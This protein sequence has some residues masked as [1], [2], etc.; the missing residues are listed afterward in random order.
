MSD[1]SSAASSDPP[2][3]LQQEK[4]QGIRRH[5]INRPTPTQVKVSFLSLLHHQISFRLSLTWLF[6]GEI[7]KAS[8]RQNARIFPIP[9]LTIIYSLCFVCCFL[10]LVFLCW[11]RGKELLLFQIFFL[12]N[13]HCEWPTNRPS[14]G[15]LCKLNKVGFPAAKKTEQ[16]KTCQRV[17]VNL[18]DQINNSC[19]ETTVQKHTSNQI[20]MIPE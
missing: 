20:R 13:L 8:L 15:G 5:P 14:F 18:Y 12:K 2:I 11:I 16:Q 1:V 9:R 4:S 10:Q 17:T 3:V 6:P 19:E 7:Q